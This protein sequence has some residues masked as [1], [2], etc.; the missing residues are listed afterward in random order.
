MGSGEGSAGRSGGSLPSAGAKG[1]EELLGDLLGALRGLRKAALD[2]VQVALLVELVAAGAEVLSRHAST[3]KPAPYRVGEVDMVRNAQAALGEVHGW[4]VRAVR[5]IDPRLGS[6]LSAVPGG[7][8]AAL[9]EGGYEP[10]LSKAQAVLQA[11]VREEQ[12]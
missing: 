1:A 7:I 4:T 5:A 6:F 10:P 9:L 12:E 2:P 3:V 8:T 11:D